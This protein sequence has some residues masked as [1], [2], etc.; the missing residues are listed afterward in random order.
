MNKKIGCISLIIF[1]LFLAVYLY[2]ATFPYKTN[3]VEDYSKT[4]KKW[5]TNIVHHFPKSIPKSATLKR[6]LC[7]VYHLFNTQGY[8][9]L[10][11][12]LSKEEIKQLYS[13]FSEK[14]TKSFFGG[15]N[16]SHANQKEGMPTTFFY[17]ADL[18]SFP[19]DYE[20]IIFDKIIPDTERTEDFRWNHGT[21]HGV[22]ISKKRNEIVYWAEMW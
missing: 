16:N 14:K 7:T 20:I 11:L 15:D 4:L 9:Q 21:S 3:N 8:I 13:Q 5:N 6:F 19:D 1:L 12:Q 18:K 17:T 22:A 10:R 2:T